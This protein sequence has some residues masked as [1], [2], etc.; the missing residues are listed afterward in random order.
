MRPG[1][2]FS[3]EEIQAEI[4]GY[5]GAIACLDDALDRLLRALEARGVLDDT[6]VIVTSDHGEEFGEHKLYTHGNSLYDAALRVPLVIAL[7]RRI[8]AGRRVAN[9]VSP[10]DL[11]ETVRD[12][13][14]PSG[15]PPFPGLSLARFWAQSGAP[16][17]EPVFS[18][19]R[20]VRGNPPWYPSAMGDMAAVMLAPYKYIQRG[21]GTEEVYDLHA[22]PGETRDLSRQVP[23][24]V[25][26]RLRA[27]AHGR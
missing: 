7:P 16:P 14:V 24:A 15:T 20:A 27:A 8:P 26:G 1:R 5:D 17:D 4:A 2:I 18:A 6:L 9:W 3:Q 22:D 23:A 21:D 25:L 13:A 10:R 11:A 12:L 19:V